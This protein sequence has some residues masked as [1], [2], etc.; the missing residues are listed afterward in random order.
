MKRLDYMAVLH[1]AMTQIEKGAFLTVK[2]GDA[3]NAMTIG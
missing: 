1:K 2:S 3:I